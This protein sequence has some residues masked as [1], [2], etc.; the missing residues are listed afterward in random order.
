MLFTKAMVREYEYLRAFKVSHSVGAFGACIV[1]PETAPEQWVKLCPSGTPS[2][3]I[4]MPYIQ[5]QTLREYL[6]ARCVTLAPLIETQE[7]DCGDNDLSREISA[8]LIPVARFCQELKTRYRHYHG[9]IK[10]GN[11]MISPSGR[12]T[13]VI[14]MAYASDFGPLPSVSSDP[15]SRGTLCYMAPEK[16]LFCEFPEGMDRENIPKSDCWSMGILAITLVLTSRKVAKFDDHKMLDENDHFNPAVTDTVFHLLDSTQPWF[17]KW[18]N[19]AKLYLDMCR[20]IFYCD[21][22]TKESIQMNY[23]LPVIEQALKFLIFCESIKAVFGSLCVGSMD[24]L[25]KS[26]LFDTITTQVVHGRGLYEDYLVNTSHP[27]EMALITVRSV[28]QKHCP[29]VLSVIQGCL[30]SDPRERYSFEEVLSELG[31]NVKP[32]TM[33]AIVPTVPDL[34]DEVKGELLLLLF[35]GQ[36]FSQSL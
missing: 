1:D 31:W 27:Y 11:I 25:K 10:M 7:K 17:V 33:P 20:R 32:E 15:W 18:M 22:T 8:V 26:R 30:R 29:H 12:E 6:R 3:A 13:W 21:P 2:L 16:I 4:V 23:A 35:L 9:D 14:D 34:M 24:Y 28:C 36:S 19:D 5:G